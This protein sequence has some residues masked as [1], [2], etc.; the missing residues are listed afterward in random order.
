MDAQSKVTGQVFFPGDLSVPGMLHMKILFAQLP[1]ARTTRLD[2]SKA[3]ASPGV[4][5]VFTEKDVPV[6]EYGLQKPDRCVMR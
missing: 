5:A 2:T 4:A 6:N 3:E 1:L